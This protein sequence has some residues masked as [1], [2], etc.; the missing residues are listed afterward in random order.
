MWRLLLGAIVSAGMAAGDESPEPRSTAASIQWTKQISGVDVHFTASNG[1]ANVTDSDNVSTWILRL[2][3]SSDA[4]AM[5]QAVSARLQSAGASQIFKGHPDQGGLSMVVARARESELRS[6]LQEVGGKVLYVEQ[7][8]E[9]EAMEQHDPPSWGLDRIDNRR[10]LDQLYAGSGASGGGG[11]HVYVVDTGIRTTHVAFEGRAIPTLSTVGGDLVVC[12]PGDTTCASDVHGHGTH[13]AGTVGSAAYGVAKAAKLHAVKTLSDSGYGMRSWILLALDWLAANA[14]RP[15]V[16]SMSLGGSGQ[17][18]A[19]KD[20]IDAL[21]AHGVVVVVAAGNYNR[22]ACNFSPAF[23]P[24]AITVGATNMGDSRSPWSNH[25]ACLDIFAPGSG[26]TSAWASS[27]SASRSISGTS[28]ACPHVSGA[29]ALLLGANPTATA[30]EVRASLVDAATA[31]AIRG[32]VGTGSPNL[33][34][35]TPAAGATTSLP[36]PTTTATL[37]ETSTATTTASMPVTTTPSATTTTFAGGHV[38]QCQCIC[39]CQEAEETSDVTF[40]EAGLRGSEPAG[41]AAAGVSLM[42]GSG[43]LLATCVGYFAGRRA[44]AAARPTFDRE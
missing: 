44:G 35:F 14:E 18:L 28:M 11:V 39:E 37:T 26:I 22:D 25:G 24:S 31:D 34:L 38:C 32:D 12:D 23:V 43:A 30:A 36:R 3:R 4:R 13:V 17:S 40:A 33:L 8:A 41:A 42:A 10:G 29:A 1:S 6:V 2:R 19:Y 7:D 5:L 27:D 20:A 9:V 21:V 15:A 16:V